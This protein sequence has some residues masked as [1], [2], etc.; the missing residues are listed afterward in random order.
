MNIFNKNKNKNKNNNNKNWTSKTELMI[1][2]DLSSD[3]IDQII[4]DFGIRWPAEIRNGTK[5]GGFH[6]LETYY[7]NYLV[8]VI[9]LK[10]KYITTNQDK[11]FIQKAKKGGI[12]L[13][14]VINSG[15]L[16]AA[17]DL[18][19]LIMEK[20]ET[21]AAFKKMSEKTETQAEKMSEQ[22]K[23]IEKEIKYLTDLLYNCKS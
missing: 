9:T 10:A 23:Q 17:K 3:T 8:A 2:L 13:N 12:L 21:Q 16:K 7:S 22:T 6:N 4:Y 14:A 20:T 19:D 15:D 11:D 1:D 18:C 5:K